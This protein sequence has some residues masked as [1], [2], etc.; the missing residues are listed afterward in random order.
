VGLRTDQREW[1]D[2]A[3]R[4]AMWAVCS[5]PGTRGRWTQAD[6]FASGEA[7][8][9][10]ILG[11]L[12]EQGLDPARGR[13]LD[14]GCGLGRLSRALAGE[15]EEVVGVD[16]SEEMLAEARRITPG[17][18][19]VV[20]D[21]PDLRQLPDRHFDFVLSLIALQHVS[22]PDAIRAYIQEF[23]RVT[24]P[25]GVIAFQLPSRVGR[26][27]TLHPLRVANRLVRRLP[28]APAPL[29]QALMGHSMRLTALPEAEVRALL[30]GARARVV[31][32]F[33]DGRGGSPQVE[34]RFYVAVKP[35]PESSS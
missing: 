2:L 32:A 10:A 6:F 34:S 4:D 14:F 19:F 25:G 20:N 29:L 33:D 12:A 8:V 21:R 9:R 31:T 13:A 11:G 18:R 35:C 24:A 1:N 22:S 23:A 28:R 26:R 15:F 7:D 3:A 17:V 30:T 5:V 16:L 27:I